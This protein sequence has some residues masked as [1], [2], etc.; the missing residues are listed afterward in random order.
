MKRIC[1]YCGSRSGGKAEYAAVASTLGQTLAEQQLTLV[2]GGA[3]VGLMG[4]IADSVLEH[5]GEVIGV[6]PKA[7]VDREIAHSG[8]T[9]LRIVESMH[10]RK[11]TMAELS[12]AFVAMPGGLGTLEELF[13]ILTWSQLGLHRKPCALLNIRHFY[14]P[15]IHFLDEATYEGF[16]QYHHRRMLVIANSP[17]SL[18]ELLREYQAPEAKQWLSQDSV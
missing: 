16:I 14:D 13:E 12:D 8:L 3:S 11:A 7:L 5:G 17:H 1:V 18:I 15:L 2:Y 6:M 9:D 4:A 10:A